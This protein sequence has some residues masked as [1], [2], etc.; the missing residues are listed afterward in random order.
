MRAIGGTSNPYADDVDYDTFLG[1][2]TE[3]IYYDW[4]YR[5]FMRCTVQE[6]KKPSDRVFVVAPAPIVRVEV[7]TPRQLTQKV[8]SPALRNSI[9]EA[10]LSGPKTSFQVAALTGYK[11]KEVYQYIQNHGY[12]YQ[13]VGMDGRRMMYG[14]A[15]QDYSDTV[16]LGTSVVKMVD[17]L[18]ANGPCEVAVLAEAVGISASGVRKFTASHPG[19]LHVV[20]REMR[21]NKMANIWGVVGLHE[22]E[23]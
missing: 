5:C 10:L 7:G 21:Y 13:P 19:V 17:Y 20:R 11:P 12:L 2:P 15:D 14:L 6:P 18:T 9:R 8:R 4:T 16:V 22:V 23:G 1:K 3:R